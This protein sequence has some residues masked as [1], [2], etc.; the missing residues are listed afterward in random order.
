M[1]EEHQNW[2]PRDGILSYEE[3][4]RVAKIS[5][6]LG[7]TKL[8]VTGGEPF[9][10]KDILPFLSQLKLI[11]NIRQIGISTNGTFFSKET[12]FDGK[13]KTYAQHVNDIG[14]TSVNISL[15][16][17]NKD[18]YSKATGRD[19][20]ENV[21]EGVDEL[22]RIGFE[23]IKLNCVLKK[24]QSECELIP[25]IEYAHQK[26]VLL[27]FIELMPVSKNEVLNE[28]SFLSVGLTKK[29]IELQL[30]KLTSDP[31]FKTNGPASY[32]TIPNSDQHIGF[33]GA[34]TNLH[35]CE[36]CNK[37]RLTADGKL[38]PCLGS[39]MEFD[40][41]SEIRKGA[42]DD[43]IKKFFIEVVSRKPK[44]HDFRDN[45]Q[46]QRHMTAIGG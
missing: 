42:T 6:E 29:I 34:M 15:D 27:R 20:L 13:T 11:R 5:S 24:N 3:I 18:T 19:Y 9:V 26:K 32:Y 28:D 10:R 39:H 7:V 21:L 40:L 31:N 22:K 37:L 14:L 45:Y 44:D 2:I 43:E 33:I 41:L 46:P 36:S 4:F 25:L 30:G 23:S 12:E 38:R 16:T 8:R 35:F 1:P 17:L